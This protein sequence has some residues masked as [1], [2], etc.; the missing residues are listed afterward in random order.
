VPDQDR[1]LAG[2]RDGSDL[3]TALLLD[4]VEE[5]SQWSRLCR[6]RPRRFDQHPACM[7]STLF[8]DPPMIGGTIA[9]LSDLRVE[10]EITH[11]L[12]GR[13]EASDIADR[14]KNAQS[15]DHIDTADGHQSLDPIVFESILGDLLLHCRQFSGYAVVLVEMPDDHASLIIRER[16]SSQ[17]CSTSFAVKLA[18][19]ARE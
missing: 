8:T 9:G 10:T 17:P 1:E 18:W 3:L 6:D 14:R 7:R 19:K 15:D 16:L 13:G 4:A 11:E 2:G 5:C 12:F